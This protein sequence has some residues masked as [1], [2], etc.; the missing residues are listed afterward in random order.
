MLPVLLLMSLLMGSVEV[1]AA[2][3]VK[4]SRQEEMMTRCIIEV[5]SNALAKP[6]APPIDPECKEILKKS[7]RPTQDDEEG[8]L[9]QYETRT[10]KDPVFLDNHQHDSKEE[11]KQSPDLPKEEYEEKRHHA[12]TESREE[13]EEEKVKETEQFDEKEESTGHSKERAFVEGEG[14]DEERDHKEHFEKEDIEKRNKY[15]EDSQESTHDMLDKRAHHTAKQTEELHEEENEDDAKNLEEILKR[16]ALGKNWKEQLLQ[17]DKFHSIHSS[18]VPEEN[19][20]WE[21]EKEKISYKPNHEELIK[22]LLGY[23]ERQGH[24]EEPRNNLADPRGQKPHFGET[25][26]ENHLIENYFDKRSHYDKESS[27]EVREKKHHHRDSE[28]EAEHHISSEESNEKEL[29]DHHYEEKRQHEERKRWPSQQNSR[30]NYEESNED[31]EESEEGIDK[32]H[33]HEQERENLYRKLKNH[34][35]ESEEAEPFRQ[36]KK[37]DEK[38]YYIGE[39]MM[40]GMKRYYPKLA[41]EKN[42]RQYEE[43]KNR[44]IREDR[45]ES[46][47]P[48]IDT[49]T[50]LWGK[51][52]FLEDL[53]RRYNLNRSS[54][55]MP[56]LEEKREYDR[57]DELAQLLNYKKKSV[58]FPDFYDSEEIK[59]RHYD[60]RER[61]RE[62]PLTEEEEKELENLAIM[63]LELQKIAEKLSNNRQG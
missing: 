63:D 52:K 1:N 56:K 45:E 7:N 5:L 2:P 14:D 47:F 15:H 6:N 30:L 46:N 50:C 59:K 38:R 44:H 55:K 25:S 41:Q 17:P 48:D 40:D 21:E 39:E 37:Q 62:T 43:S 26:L 28:E 27:E 57:M 22:R 54:S 29:N 12:E 18:K 42:L 51:K 3:F 24:H 8:E 61:F 9:K 20:E 19:D 23:E 60:E 32:R 34:L 58:E 31:S 16:H 35:Q 4:G 11:A 53:R 33:E 13:K 10:I 49:Y 36:E